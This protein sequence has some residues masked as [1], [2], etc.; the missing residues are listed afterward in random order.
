MLDEKTRFA[1]A[2]IIRGFRSSLP[3]DGSNAPR[4]FPSKIPTADNDV[5]GTEV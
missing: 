1:R 4:E 3:P 5:R 2:G